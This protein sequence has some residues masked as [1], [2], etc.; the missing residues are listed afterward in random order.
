M[1]WLC[2]S[3]IIFYFFSPIY[4]FSKH[5]FIHQTKLA[6]WAFSGKNTARRFTD[7]TFNQSKNWLSRELMKHEILTWQSSVI[8]HELLKSVVLRSTKRIF[9]LQINVLRDS[10]TSTTVKCL[11][12][13]WGAE[14]QYRYCSHYCL[15]ALVLSLRSLPCQL[16]WP[17]SQKNVKILTY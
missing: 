16:Y 17:A 2:S 13:S 15:K 8:L 5:V 14:I 3:L 10:K 6:F 4:V 9:S 11:P 7:A 12:K 1:F